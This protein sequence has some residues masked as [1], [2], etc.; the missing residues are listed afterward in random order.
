MPLA[1]I[2]RLGRYDVTAVLGEGT[3]GRVPQPWGRK[4][5]ERVAVRGVLLAVGVS[6]LVVSQS[7]A[8]TDLPRTAWGAPDLN[9]LWSHGTATLLERPERH[10]GR[11]RLTDEEVAAVNAV[12]R[13]TA[14]VGARRA[15]W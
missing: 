6:M 13:S 7:G 8:Q 11:E 9:G 5:F 10:A 12:A 14:G 4:T 15:V 2:T 1:P 3:G